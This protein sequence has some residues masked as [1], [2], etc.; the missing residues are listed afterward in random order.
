MALAHSKADIRGAC[1][2]RAYARGLDY[3]RNHRVLDIDLKETDTDLQVN[4]RVR[5]NAI[6]SQEIHVS[7]FMDVIEIEGEC[8]CPV[9]SSMADAT[10]PLNGGGRGEGFMQQGACPRALSTANNEQS[11]E[12]S[13]PRCIQSRTGAL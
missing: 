10:A 8:T 7:Q 13:P 3:A 4:S 12:T 11:P 6:Y 2:D 9:G 5:G 1:G